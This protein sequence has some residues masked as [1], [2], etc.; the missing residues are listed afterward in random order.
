LDTCFKCCTFSIDIGVT[1]LPGLV[2]PSPQLASKIRHLEINAR[3]CLEFNTIDHML[4]NPYSFCRWLLRPKLRLDESAWGP[5]YV[6]LRERLDI[7]M[8]DW[9]TEWQKRFTSLK[10]LDLVINVY[11]RRLSGDPELDKVYMRLVEDTEMFL[12]A[13]EVYATFSNWHD[14]KHATWTRKNQL[15]LYKF[16]TSLEAWIEGSMTRKK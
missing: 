4:V 11:S 14:L 1:S 8:G 10:S 16:M 3:E 7:P 2:V 15:N 9:E 12:Q 6:A 5:Y 13:D